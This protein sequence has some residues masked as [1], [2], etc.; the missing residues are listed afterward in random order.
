MVSLSVNVECGLK[1]NI[2]YSTLAKYAN[3]Q[4]GKAKYKRQQGRILNDKFYTKIT[5]FCETISDTKTVKLCN[6]IG[7][8]YCIIRC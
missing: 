8:G 5:F 2:S 4:K 3:T 7:R 1:I 6:T